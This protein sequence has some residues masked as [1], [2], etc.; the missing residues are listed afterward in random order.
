MK[1]IS[2]FDAHCDT[3]SRCWREYEELDRN[4]GMVSLERTQKAFGRY[5]QI[6]ALWT[7]EGYTGYP[8]GGNG[9]ENAYR[10][11]LRCFRAQMTRHCGCIVQCRTADDVERAHRQ[12]KAAA[13]LSIEGAELIGCDPARL[14]QAAEDGV[15]SINLTWNH[16]NA[17]SGSHG[18]HPEQGLTQLGRQFVAKMEDCH[19]LVDVSHLSEA[20]FWDVMEQVRRPILASH[21]NAKSV[22]N[23]T[24]NLTDGQITAIIKNRG[25][26][27]LN[28]YK[29][30][31]GG[32][33]D[34]DMLRAHL[35]HILELGGAAS[36]GL[37]GDWDG[38][39]VIDALPSIDKLGR[40]YEYLL[41]RG[42]HETVVR[43]LF[44]NNLM[45]VVSQR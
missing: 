5:C 26:I 25:V 1:P 44:Y 39:D 41:N 16:A 27:G 7:A 30:F 42:Y 45:R 33:R 17:L 20:G 14:E 9:V 34:L 12:G 2:V 6:F 22:W 18:S 35:D 36:V 11:L 13:F 4:S 38:C 24:R 31:V 32:N 3:I 8:L 23:H 15:V 43:D 28:L 29:D 37:G 10:A 40:F 19:I 21:S